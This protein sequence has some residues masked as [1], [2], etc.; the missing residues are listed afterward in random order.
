MNNCKV[1]KMIS[2]SQKINYVSSR[3]SKPESHQTLQHMTRRIVQHHFIATCIF[4]VS[5]WLLLSLT[6]PNHM[7]FARNNLNQI[8]SWKILVQVE[9]GTPIEE[10]MR[11]YEEGLALKLCSGNDI[12]CHTL[13]EERWFEEI[14]LALINVSEWGEVAGA[15][16]NVAQLK[17]FPGVSIAELDLQN[18]RGMADS[19]AVNDGGLITD[20]PDLHDPNKS[21]APQQILMTNGWK[22]TLGS[23]AVVIAI[24]DTGI[25]AEHIEFAGRIVQGMDFVNDDK[26]PDDDHGH[27]THAAGIIAAAAD[28]G[29]G[30][31][32]ICPKCKIMPIKVLTE[33]N[34][35]NW[36]DVVAG[37]MYAA[38]N[39]AQ[40][41]NLS[42]G[43]TMPSD[44]VKEA[45]DYAHNDKGVLIIAAAGNWS[46]DEPFYPASFEETLAVSATDQAS[47]LWS[48]SN[49]GDYVDV[50]A[51]GDRIYSTD[52]NLDDNK[53]GFT[54]RSG[55]SM[56][57]AHV[58]GLAG[59][60]LSQDT[61]YSL[62]T[63]KTL[64]TDH[65]DDL[66][67]ASRDDQF[68]SGRINVCKAMDAQ[69][70][71]PAHNPEGNT[72]DSQPYR[73]YLPLVDK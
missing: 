42:L 11:I 17:S 45:I 4:I 57:A 10:R 35:G 6:Y 72:L 52:S 60:L 49:F 61:T 71:P 30:S 39:G 41:I 69:Y 16:P 22:H 53:A 70:G 1:Q 58:S 56:A 20:D 12:S 29:V 13:E 27:G 28:N 23:D 32:G 33:N 7:L 15:A 64:I 31:A 37:I 5:L 59:L 55:T 34:V 54:F 24:L 47:E 48:L 38:N 9:D 19:S 36:S 63:L 2:F 68:G 50:S 26:N 65:A 62:E 73:L 66:G 14:N 25:N 43:S 44:S 67:P 21:Y 51:P 8:S 18:V 40:I 46:T 3:F